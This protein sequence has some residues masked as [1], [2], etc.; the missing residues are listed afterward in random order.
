MLGGNSVASDLGNGNCELMND[1]LLLTS[2]PK[3][4]ARSVTDVLR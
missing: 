1:S 2:G 4:V 3:S